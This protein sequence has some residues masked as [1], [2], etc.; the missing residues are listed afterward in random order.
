MLSVYQMMCPITATKMSQMVFLALTY[1]ALKNG[2]LNCH[3]DFYEDFD[4]STENKKKQKLLVVDTLSKCKLH[5]THL[6]V[7]VAEN[8]ESFSHSSV[9][10]KHAKSLSEIFLN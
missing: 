5:F 9:A 2:V 3:L 7:Y 1:F 4:E 8:T 10:V 6:S